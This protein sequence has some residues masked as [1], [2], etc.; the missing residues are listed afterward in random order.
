MLPKKRGDIMR[1]ETQIARS[2]RDKESDIYPEKQE[3]EKEQAKNQHKKIL[4]AG[5]NLYI[6]IFEME[7]KGWHQH[8]GYTKF[9]D[10]TNNEL[11]IPESTYHD[12][13]QAIQFRKRLTEQYDINKYIKIPSGSLR[14]LQKY[15]GDVV[16]KKYEGKG[17]SDVV[18]D[19]K[20]GK[21]YSIKT[22]KKF[23]NK[24][25]RNFPPV[26]RKSKPRKVEQA[27]YELDNTLKR[28][29]RLD[30][31]II[32]KKLS[33]VNDEYAEYVLAGKRLDNAEWDSVDDGDL[34]KIL[35]DYKHKELKLA[36]AAG[37]FAE[38]F[39][40]RDQIYIARNILKKIKSNQNDFSGIIDILNQELRSKG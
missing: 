30:L 34:E 29:P 39:K 28:L 35:D 2:L 18:Y 38:S 1:K 23:T 3:S 16:K 11:G 5:R 8:F 31:G 15:E 22:V 13:K 20:K 12:N 40:D 4:S 24:E 17:L 6:L 9:T 32:G 26:P 14:L 37:S 33:D 27:E 25:R 7:A 21:D 36:V 10:Y 19:L